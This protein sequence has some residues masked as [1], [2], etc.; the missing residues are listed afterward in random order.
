MAKIRQLLQA[1]Q[2]PKFNTSFTTNKTRKITILQILEQTFNI[3]LVNQE[4]IFRFKN[5]MSYNLKQIS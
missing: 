2:L 5:K 4:Y 1:I 3:A